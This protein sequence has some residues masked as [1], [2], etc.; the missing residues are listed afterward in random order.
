[1]RETGTNV[2]VMKQ[3]DEI[4]QGKTEILC[5][6]PSEQLAEEPGS[7]GASMV[8]RVSYGSFSILLT[9]DLEG[10]GEEE[11]LSSGLCSRCTVLK[12]AHHGSRNSG[13]EAFLEQT[14][15]KAALISA[16]QENRYGHPHEETL[17]RLQDCG[18]SIYSTQTYGAVT[19]WTDGEKVRIRH[20]R[21]SGE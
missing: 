11:L 2:S 10:K 5:L 12:A 9:G 7:N 8:L 6:A 14:A 20:F 13:S 19:V 15:P 1:M 17:K 18:C 16:G 4:R 3:G 21:M